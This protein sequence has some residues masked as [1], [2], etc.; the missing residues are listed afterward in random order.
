M[1]LILIGNKY[2][3]FTQNILEFFYL[4][5]VTFV[6]I[7]VQI[8]DVPHWKNANLEKMWCWNDH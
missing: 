1:C 4:K 6:F 3:L 5:T 2:I 7:L 8:D